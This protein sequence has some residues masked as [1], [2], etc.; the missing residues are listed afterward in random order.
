MNTCTRTLRRK[1][2]EEDVARLGTEN[3]HL[4]IDIAH[5][6]FERKKITAKIKPLD[7]RSD[8]IVH[9][10]VSGEEERDV[11]C[12]WHYDYKNR[13]K[14]LYA[15]DNW[16][17]I[18]TDSI[19]EHEMQKLL[20]DGTVQ[21]TPTLF[22][23]CPSCLYVKTG[24]PCAA[25][26]CGNPA[27]IHRSIPGPCEHP[28]ESR[29]EES[30]VVTCSICNT[31]LDIAPISREMQAVEGECDA[32]ETYTPTEEIMAPDD[33]SRPINV[34]EEAVFARQHREY[35]LGGESYIGEDAA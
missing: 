33:D 19:K 13:I 15:T 14:R 10:I 17:I 3:A 11:V 6:K 8:E 35:D 1:L 25:A 29:V 26:L 2:T 23:S 27:M 16:E 32:P 34:A 20:F 5:L 21:T 30:N 18:E 12:E 24:N 22:S 9:I 7:E 31:V 28:I 4:Q